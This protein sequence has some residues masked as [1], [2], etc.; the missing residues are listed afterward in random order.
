MM[1][2]D[3][4]K[5][6]KP[7]HGNRIGLDLGS[8]SVKM[9]EVS[10]T[11]EAP[12]LVSFGVKKL[13][14]PSSDDATDAIRA[15]AEE[16]KVSAKECTIS[17]A[18]PSLIA[19]LISMPKMTDEELKNAAIFE[20]EKFIPFDVNDCVLDFNVHGA[21]PREK[22]NL[23]IL[24]AAAKRD[25]VL[26]KIKMVEDA[27]FTVNV[28]DVDSFAVTNAFL[29]NATQNENAKTVALLNIGATY[30]NL[31]ILRAGLISSVR[32]VAIGT[33]DFNSIVSKKCGVEG[34]ISD[35]LKNIPADKTGEIMACA[36]AALGKLLDEAKL[37]FGYH[38]NQFGGAIEEVYLSGGGAGFPAIEEAFSEALGSKPN[39]WNPFQFMG[40]DPAIINVDNIVKFK[41]SFAVAVGLALR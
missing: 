12:S 26:Q 13:Q 2:F 3:I 41:D 21:D 10:G 35:A 40:I 33:N 37:S 25:F 27:G 36:K 16:L 20:I 28:I 29:K 9:L 31:V 24:L 4:L 1:N 15:L 14:G 32:D 18:G 8:H 6:F 22:N 5:K 30:T 19:R 11:P 17:L 34:D 7:H 39:K 38:E 23:N